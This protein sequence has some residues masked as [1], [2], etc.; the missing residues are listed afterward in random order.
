M[1][2][3]LVLLMPMLLMHMRLHH[4]QQLQQVPSFPLE[5]LMGPGWKHQV[6]AEAKAEE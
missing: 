5:P 3:D 6:Q 1:E 4:L 2:Q